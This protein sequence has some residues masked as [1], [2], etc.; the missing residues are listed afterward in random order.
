MNMCVYA[1]TTSRPGPTRVILMSFEWCL[2]VCWPLISLQPPTWRIKTSRL[3]VRSI[4]SRYI[5]VFTVHI[6]CYLYG[7]EWDKWRTYD[8]W[9][10][11]GWRRHNFEV[12][13]VLHGELCYPGP[14]STRVVL[15]KT[16]LISRRPVVAMQRGRTG[17][18]LTW[19]I[20]LPT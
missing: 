3:P 12:T 10:D 8:T 14:H 17:G 1:H 13:G 7:R 6:A 9:Y 4:T 19:K 15:F 2:F 18:N 5:L 16:C 11:P 20:L